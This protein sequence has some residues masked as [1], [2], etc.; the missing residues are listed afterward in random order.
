MKRLILILL[1]SACSTVPTEKPDFKVLSS[2][3]PVFNITFNNQTGS[4]PAT[5]SQTDNETYHK[6]CTTTPIYGIDGQL[7][8]NDIQCQ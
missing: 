8:R 5:L 7:V 4:S 3:P 6:T 2:P 1:C